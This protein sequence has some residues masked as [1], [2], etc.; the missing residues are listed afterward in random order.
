MVVI[1]KSDPIP[2][3]LEYPVFTKAIDMIDGRK[4][5]EHKCD[6]RQELQ[7]AINNS[8][9]EGLLV[10]QYIRKV[11]EIDYIGYSANGE[12][13]IPYIQHQLR[14]S[15]EAYGGYFR[16]DK[17]EGNETLNKVYDLLRDIRF[18]GLFSVEFLVDQNGKWFFTEVNFRHDGH[19][20]LITNAGIN[21]PWLYCCA[22]TGQK[23]N[24]KPSVKK[25]TFTGMNELVDIEQ[26][27]Y[28]RK[29]NKW[30]WIKQCLL[31][32]THILWNWRDMKPAVH[33]FKK[34][35]FKI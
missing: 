35:F 23:V 30:K 1:K 22:M 3:D 9:Q 31:A 21:L 19:D 29:I 13:Y 15:D 6:N 7:Q 25:N 18:N 12:I 10:Q 11:D 8:R 28:T 34:H 32:D 5:D 24:L 26:F 17:A 14:F 27:I 16:F 4:K 20:Y 2:D 33:Y